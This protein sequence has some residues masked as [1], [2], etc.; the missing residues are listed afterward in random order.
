MFIVCVQ[1]YV[2]NNKYKNKDEWDD[3][4]S[5]RLDD[6]VQHH[7][8]EWLVQQDDPLEGLLLLLTS[9]SDISL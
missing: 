1:L 3:P 4:S 9:A 6:L 7:D 8:S 2:C 5:S